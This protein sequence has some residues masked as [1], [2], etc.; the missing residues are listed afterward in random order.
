MNV[1]LHCFPLPP[2]PTNCLGQHHCQQPPHAVDPPS[3]KRVLV[4]VAQKIAENVHPHTKPGSDTPSGKRFTTPPQRNSF[5]VRLYSS[6]HSV[7]V[8]LYPL[9]WVALEH[10]PSHTRSQLWQ[11]G[12]KENSPTNHAHP[13]SA[14]LSVFIQKGNLRPCSELNSVEGAGQHGIR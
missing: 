9:M 14:D 10:T 1:S 13:P 12:D 7:G 2:R 6:G 11:I 5:G 3:R 4:D 8:R